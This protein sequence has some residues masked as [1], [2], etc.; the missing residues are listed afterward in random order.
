MGGSS[1]KMSHSATLSFGSL[2]SVYVRLQSAVVSAIKHI[3][4]NPSQATPGAFLLLQFRMGQVTQ[5][6]ESI[7]N[8]IQQVQ[9]IIKNAIGNQRV[10]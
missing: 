2:I 10:T 8:L 7:S 4:S 1:D 9:S 3:A 5:I 6:G